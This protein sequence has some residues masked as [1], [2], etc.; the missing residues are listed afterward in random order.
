MNRL[1]IIVGLF[2]LLS[3]IGTIYMFS[4]GFAQGMFSLLF[5]CIIFINYIF[6]II[7]SKE[8]KIWK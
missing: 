3:L 7:K 2:L 5:T 8:E 4:F 6:I 1:L